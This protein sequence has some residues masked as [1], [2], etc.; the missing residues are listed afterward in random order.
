MLYLNLS[1]NAITVK[2]VVHGCIIH[3]ISKSD[4]INLLKRYVVN[5]QAF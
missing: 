4:A 5:D 3:E 1:D 2:A